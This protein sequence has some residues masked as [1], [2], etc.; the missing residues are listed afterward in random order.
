MLPSSRKP[1]GTC[2]Y[3]WGPGI[4]FINVSI[5]PQLWVKFEQFC[6]SF[7]NQSYQMQHSHLLPL[8]ITQRTPEQ[9]LSFFSLQSQ[10]QSCYKPRNIAFWVENRSSPAYDISLMAKKQTK[11]K[12]SLKHKRIQAGQ[13]LTLWLYVTEN[14][15]RTALCTLASDPCRSAKPSPGSTCRCAASDN[16]PASAPRKNWTPTGNNAGT[17]SGFPYRQIC[18]AGSPELCTA[19][20]PGCQSSHL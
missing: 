13:L 11:M 6:F 2:V 7:D 8:P 14:Q 1:W 3:H 20:P 12:K 5:S 4:V 15:N 18:S 10:A 9:K 17:G 16:G 19:G